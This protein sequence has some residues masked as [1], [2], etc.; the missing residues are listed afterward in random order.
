[1]KTLLLLLLLLLTSCAVVDRIEDPHWILWER[2]EALRVVSV[3]DDWV[4]LE[5]FSNPA[6]NYEYRSHMQIGDTLILTDD[7]RAKLKWK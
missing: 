1:M 4:T 6:R 7:I 3:N 5:S 2:T